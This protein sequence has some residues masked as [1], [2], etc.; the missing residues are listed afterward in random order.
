MRPGA[1][2]HFYRQTMEADVTDV[3]PSI[4]TPTLEQAAHDLLQ[5]LDK[6]SA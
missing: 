4:R 1:Y 3:I 2:G 5:M 6:V